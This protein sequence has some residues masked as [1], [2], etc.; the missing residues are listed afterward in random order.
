MKSNEYLRL[1]GIKKNKVFIG[2][3]IVEI[4]ISNKCNFNCEYCWTHNPNNLN[5]L[6]KK[7]LNKKIDFKI[8]KK[9][10]DDLKELKTKQIL[11]SGVGEPF[12]HPDIIKMIKYVKDKKFE[13]KIT[14]NFSLLNKEK[15]NL[16]IKYNV[17]FLEI[18]IS[19]ATAITYVKVHSN[20]TKKTFQKI[21]ENLDYLSHL[22]KEKIPYTIFANIITKNN[23]HEILKMINFGKRYNANYI[24]FIPI[25]TVKQTKYLLL[26]PTIIK[27][28]IRNKKIEKCIK[29]NEIETNWLKF[30][31]QISNSQAKNGFYNFGTYDKLGC[32]IGWY[33][34][35]IW[36]EGYVSP[37]CKEN[38]NAPI[39]NGNFKS[40]WN[41]TY[42]NEFRKGMKNMH[43]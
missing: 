6:S 29:K 41:S 17:D 20:Q 33:F 36:V 23:C 18:N 37:C 25:D 12:T 27:K 11:F 9:I 13:L 43:K 4:D 5:N 39:N 22:K 26:T 19:A 38:L 28:I 24:E 15:I 10:L 40:V 35:K 14:T 1:L 8:L 34:S 32:Y 2:P 7:Y 42:F 16:L 31:E 21:K 3:E 30:T